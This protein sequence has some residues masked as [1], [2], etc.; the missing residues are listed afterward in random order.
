MDE[1]VTLHSASLFSFVGIDRVA[2][3]DLNVGEL[4][5]TAVSFDR[6]SLDGIVSPVSGQVAN[7]RESARQ[8]R[9]FDV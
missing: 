3:V 4:F 6:R 1:Q 2:D 7:H 8:V 5:Q 9:K